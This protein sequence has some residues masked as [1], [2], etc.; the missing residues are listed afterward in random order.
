MTNKLYVCRNLTEAPFVQYNASPNP[1][2]GGIYLYV[3]EHKTHGHPHL[4]IGMSRIQIPALESRSGAR[5][6]SSI[7]CIKVVV[8]VVVE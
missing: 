6:L 5:I 8:V 1:S 3:Y 7:A 4:V 2:A